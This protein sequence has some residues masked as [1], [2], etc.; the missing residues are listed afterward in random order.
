MKRPKKSPK[1]FSLIEA[2]ISM[3]LAGILLYVLSGWIAFFC[4]A[5]KKF[6]ESTTNPFPQSLVYLQRALDHIDYDTFS[7]KLDAF[8]GECRFAYTPS[9]GRIKKHPIIYARI[10]FE[11]ST[12]F[13]EKKGEKEDLIER[14][15]LLKSDEKPHISLLGYLLEEKKTCFTEITHLKEG[16]LFTPVFLRVRSK[17]HQF[18]ASLPT[19]YNESILLSLRLTPTKNGN[20]CS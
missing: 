19:L 3:L 5:S 12:L 17:T 20:V 6:E 18:D 16:D 15:P 2:M 8:S 9:G 13:F 11:N 1:G 10:Y 7:L 14:L 4:F